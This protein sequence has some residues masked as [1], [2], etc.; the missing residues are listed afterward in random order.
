MADFNP[1]NFLNRIQLNPFSQGVVLRA[2]VAILLFFSWTKIETYD[3]VPV[4]LHA[5]SYTIA[6]YNSTLDRDGSILLLASLLVSIITTFYLKSL[7]LTI[8]IMTIL[9]MF[10]D[11]FF[12]FQGYM[13]GKTYLDILLALG[14]CVFTHKFEISSR[15]TDLLTVS[16]LLILAACVC[17]SSS[18]SFFMDVNQLLLVTIG[19]AQLIAFRLKMFTEIVYWFVLILTLL[20]IYLKSLRN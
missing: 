7:L 19:L 2:F 10:L 20:W 5:L 12:D 4:C 3:K 6:W 11:P 16:K 14:Q 9:S 13:L 17:L 8:F 18:T 1:V 15:L